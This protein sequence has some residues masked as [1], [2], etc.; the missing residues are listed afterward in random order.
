MKD[1][2]RGPYAFSCDSSNLLLALILCHKTDISFLEIVV[3]GCQHCLLGITYLHEILDDEQVLLWIRKP[4]HRCYIS[5]LVEDFL[6]LNSY[7][8]FWDPI[9]R[10]HDQI[11]LYALQTS[12]TIFSTHIVKPQIC[13]MVDLLWIKCHY[14]LKGSYVFFTIYSKHLWT[15]TWNTNSYTY[16]CLTW[17]LLI[18]GTTGKLYSTSFSQP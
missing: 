6:G 2:C 17:I 7:P 11:S 8:T 5:S 15:S 16:M 14:K 12:F 1:L 18:I 10:L 3:D 13:A 9:S 4:H